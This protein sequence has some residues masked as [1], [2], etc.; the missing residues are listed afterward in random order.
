MV[1]LSLT[2]TFINDLE[3][4]DPYSIENDGKLCPPN[5]PLN[6]L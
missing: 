3:E 4:S 1:N 5:F 2:I 6:D